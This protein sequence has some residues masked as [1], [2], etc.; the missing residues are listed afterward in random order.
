MPRSRKPAD[1]AGV[2]RL[3]QA[4]IVAALSLSPGAANADTAVP[5]PRQQ[6]VPG[7]PAAT[8]LVREIASQVIAMHD[9]QA[10]PFIIVDKIGAAAFVF[11]AHGSLQ[12]AAPVLLGLAIGDDAVP[13]IGQRPLAAI[14]RD[15]RTTP[16]GRFVAALDHNLAGKEVLWVDYDN[17]IS[18][19]P[20][21]KGSAGDHR[22][23]RLASA[24]PADNRISYGCINVP[25]R[26]FDDLVSPLFRPG[27]G[28][29]YVL[30]ETR[31]AHSVFGMSGTIAPSP[32]DA[33]HDHR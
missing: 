9:N 23:A 18:L 13:G 29:V 7:G 16:A 25:L 15:E 17:A 20:V 24:T 10:L 12:G 31:P 21:V 27:G 1:K 33:A 22:A 8:D 2:A 26:F 19:H 28:I 4:A 5:G 14:R 3:G 32:E 6:V 11:S 30:P